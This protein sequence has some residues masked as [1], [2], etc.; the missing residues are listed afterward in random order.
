MKKW[1][2]SLFSGICLANLLSAADTE[3]VHYI[4]Q[5]YEDKAADFRDFCGQRGIQILKR[6]AKSAWSI[7]V[8]VGVIDEL[9]LI[10]KLEIGKKIDD[11]ILI[12]PV[13]DEVVVRFH[14]DVSSEEVQTLLASFGAEALHTN[15]IINAVHIRIRIDRLRNLAKHDFVEYIEEKPP[16]PEEDND[17]ARSNTGVDT[18]QDPSGP[19]GLTGN[20]VIATVYDGGAIFEHSDLTGRITYG[21]SASI[22]AH[23]THVAG[24]LGGDGTA[25]PTYK[26][27]APGCSLISYDYYGY[28]DT[29]YTEAV[30]TYSAHIITNSWHSGDVSEYTSSCEAVDKIIRD[31]NIVITWSAGNSR[32]DGDIGTD[33]ADP[34]NNYASIDGGGKNAKNVIVVGAID[35]TDNSMTSYSGWGPRWD[36]SIAPTVVAPGVGI[37]S[38]GTSSTTDYV[39]YGGTSTSTPIVAGI[40][41]LMLE[42]YFTTTGSTTMPLPSTI[43][44]IIA[45]TADDLGRNGPDYTYGFGKIN[46]V[47][48]VD[49][50]INS[51]YYESAISSTG[52]S[53][54]QTIS[55]SSGT[56]MLKVTL[57]WD[58]LEGEYLQN[59]LDL[60]LIS[61][62]GKHY[63]PRVLDQDNPS[64]YARRGVD[65]INTIEDAEVAYPL[66]GTWKIVVAG[67]SI[68]E[69]QGFSIAYYED[70]D[71]LTDIVVPYHF[72]S[73]ATASRFCDSGGT[74]TVLSGTYTETK[75]IRLKSNVSLIGE[76]ADSVIL[77]SSA[78]DTIVVS[79]GCTIQGINI[80]SSQTGVYV[81]R[82]AGVTIQNCIFNGIT[83]AGIVG[84]TGATV[85]IINVTI[86]QCGTG[87]YIK[88]TGE[89]MN[90]IISQSTYGLRYTRMAAISESYN[91]FYNNTNNYPSRHTLG[92]GSI[93]S[94]PLWVSGT[95]YYISST[96][97]CRDVGNPDSAYNDLDGTQND[98][99]WHGGPDGKQIFP[100][101]EL[102]DDIT[103]GLG[104]TYCL[105]VEDVSDPNGEALSYSWELTS[106]P[107]GSS[108]TTA[109]LLDNN[110]AE[111]IFTPDI[112]GDYIFTLNIT[113]SSGLWNSSQQ[114]ITIREPDTITVDPGGGGDYT[115]IR[116]AIANS[117]PGDTILVNSG[118]YSDGYMRITIPGLHIKGAGWEDTVMDASGYASGFYILTDSST[119]SYGDYTIVEGLSIYGTTTYGA[120]F[121]NEAD[122]VIVQNN[123]FYDSQAGVWQ[124]L[125]SSSTIRNNIIGGCTYGIYAS[126]KDMF[127]Y[128]NIINNCE[129]GLYLRNYYYDYD[130]ILL[131]NNCITNTDTVIHISIT[132]GDY[133]IQYNT[134]WDCDDTTYTEN[135]NIFEDPLFTGFTDDSDYTNDD[136]TL[137]SSSPCVDKGISVSDFNDVDGT[138]S[139]MGIYGG[140]AG[141][142]STE[143]LDWI[144]I[145]I[146]EIESIDNPPT[147]DAGLDKTGSVGETITL[148]V[149]ASDPDLDTLTYS[150]SIDSA[151]SGS[152]AVI[153][154]SVSFIPDVKGDYTITLTVSDG[155]NTASDSIVITC[156]N[157]APVSNAG[158]DQTASVGDTITLDATGSSDS[159]GDTLTYS[160][161]IKYQPDDSAATL[162]NSNTSTPT[163]TID[164][165]GLYW[166]DLVVNDATVDSNPDSMI[167]LCGLSGS[168]I[169]VPDSYST[170]Q[171]AVDNAASG[172]IIILRSGTY[173]ETVTL[174][175]GIT[176]MGEGPETTILDASENLYG[177]VLADDTAV[178]RMTIHS[179][180]FVNIYGSNVGNVNI[181]QNIISESRGYG[182]WF[183]DS[184]NIIISNNILNDN[185]DENLVVGSGSED[186]EIINNTILDSAYGIN[187]FHEYNNNFIIKNNIIAY[188]DIGLFGYPSTNN[189]NIESDYNYFYGN[190]DDYD[191]S[192][193]I[194]T[195]G[196]ND[197][198]GTLDPRFIS[199]T[200]NWE[201]NDLHLSSSSPCID[202]G[203]PDPTY[204][205][206]DGTMNDIG[207]FGGP[208]GNW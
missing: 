44:A 54:V 82:G 74:I 87:I 130:R 170:I 96:S 75:A 58:D 187:I 32:D 106:V 89:I 11:D 100:E 24:T 190:T 157:T 148:D 118:T 57:A 124:I 71:P 160:W 174:T 126:T 47:A 180:S 125:G 21:D 42:Q 143:Y 162:A 63:F 59:D 163:I 112:A 27:M 166:I 177:I 107:S 48:A 93:S 102:P 81:R 65:D 108:L 153:D 147:V 154:D 45:N 134:A 151:P 119:N 95:S 70:T 137:S 67:T 165:E 73:I 110:T 204:N 171:E 36:G 46:A 12:A 122:R 64:G 205:D 109:D 92:T 86:D 14:K 13:E 97:P 30:N 199:Y 140:P 184:D 167:I 15:K 186:V 29:E 94:D 182:I 25:D 17:G 117:Q 8:P 194:I 56:T 34:D 183:Y 4:V 169:V 23:T 168:V 101:I 175:S 128:N 189:T 68:T 28:L 103:L 69:A 38:T 129:Y 158:V 155:V 41:S 193:G 132:Q 172:D 123:C 53:S 121:I 198:Y 116:T 149:S 127:A 208:D 10:G 26:G 105:F 195:L 111:P 178:S 7:S 207:A 113:N 6:K 88:G 104:R 55:V 33:P 31:S 66:A 78:A 150:W 16:P 37:T 90:S 176:I 206:T 114:T 115:T 203:D 161:T 120:I 39:Q 49:S 62:K 133:L 145:D 9:K 196:G 60:I 5:P 139:D 136:F 19:Y 22:S 50:I 80:S 135:R 76:G 131:L 152:S 179:A 141:D 20:G 51:T 173:E 85:D 188:N 144:K 77:N 200:G 79:D 191:D 159:D 91:D 2:L 52:Q 1:L 98:I 142:Y 35:D 99:G 84:D 72:R 61:P 202:A 40:S 181:S 3:R 201:N 156:N 138:R 192:G 185:V 18:L 83:N 43:R 197:I 164:V 146:G